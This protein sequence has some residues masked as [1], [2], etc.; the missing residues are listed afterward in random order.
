MTVIYAVI[1]GSEWEDIEY[2][3]SEG[4]A[5]K[6]LNRDPST[7]VAKYIS[8]SGTRMILD[9]LYM[10]DTDGDIVFNKHKMNMTKKKLLPEGIE[11]TTFG[12]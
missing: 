6:F 4:C 9:G 2:F 8:E 1:Y 3:V 7:I 5:L 12:S 10:V 11:P